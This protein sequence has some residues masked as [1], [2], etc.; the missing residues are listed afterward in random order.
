[1]KCIDCPQFK[2]A[3]NPLKVGR[4][5]YDSGLAVCNKHNLEVEFINRRRLN[6]LDCVEDTMQRMVK[7]DASH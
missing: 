2:V 3:Y 7:H 6:T 5:V 1:M 4:D